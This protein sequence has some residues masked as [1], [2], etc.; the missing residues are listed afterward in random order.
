MSTVLEQLE[1][2]PE[3]YRSEAINEAKRT[4]L[5]PPAAYNYAKSPS[6]ALLELKWHW[7]KKGYN[8]WEKVHKETVRKELKDRNYGKD[9]D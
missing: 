2:L 8:Y 7:T 9:Q 1:N 6:R 4:F 3:P 5:I